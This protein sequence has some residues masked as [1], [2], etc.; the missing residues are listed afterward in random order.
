MAD[1]T[2]GHAFAETYDQHQK[3]VARLRVIE[4]DLREPPAPDAQTPARAPAPPHKPRRQEQ[5]IAV[6]RGAISRK[7]LPG[8]CEGMPCRTA[9][10]AK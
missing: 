10:S 4:H 8:G 7:P 9:R 5:L 6:R 1:G 2:G 3:N